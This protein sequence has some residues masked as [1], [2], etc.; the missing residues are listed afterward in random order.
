MLGRNEKPN[1]KRAC[2]RWIASGLGR[3]GS[4]SSDEVSDVERERKRWIERHRCIETWWSACASE[5]SS[6]ALA[7][8]VVVAYEQ[9][10]S[11]NKTGRLVCRQRNIRPRKEE[12]TSSRRLEDHQVHCG[13]QDSLGGRYRGAVEDQQ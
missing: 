13:E 10:E 8:R 7:R 1:S 3:G 6:Q 11:H 12:I 9:E 2:V 5:L 4:E